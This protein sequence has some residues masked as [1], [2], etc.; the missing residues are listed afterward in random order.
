MED[1]KNKKKKIIDDTLK[2]SVVF[3]NNKNVNKSYW[4][5]F[6]SYFK[7]ASDTF[8]F[9]YLSRTLKIKYPENTKLQIFNNVFDLRNKNEKIDFENFF[10]NIIFFHIEQ[11]ILIKKVL[12]QIKIIIQ[13]VDGDV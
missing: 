4:G 12:K 3:I 2:N 6:K 11:I 1:D 9:N 10:Q 5:S 13:I 7:N 8:K